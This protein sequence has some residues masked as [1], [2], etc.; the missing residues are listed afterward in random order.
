MDKISYKNYILCIEC[1]FYCFFQFMAQSVCLVWSSFTRMD[2]WLLHENLWKTAN[3]SFPSVYIIKVRWLLLVHITRIFSVLC[4]SLIKNLVVL[5]HSLH[6]QNV[7]CLPH[8]YSS[9]SYLSVSCASSRSCVAA[10]W[11]WTTLPQTPGNL[12]ITTCSVSQ[13]SSPQKIKR[14]NT[15]PN[16]I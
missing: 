8:V 13:K 7:F 14:Y 12:T 9:I 2:P 1:C 3:V 16:P 4:I 10:C 11:A 6:C 15:S 5:N